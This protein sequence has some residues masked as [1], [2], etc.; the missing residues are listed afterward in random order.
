MKKPAANRERYAHSEMMKLR[1]E[2]RKIAAQEPR[3]WQADKPWQGFRKHAVTSGGVTIS[4]SGS[5]Q[6]DPDA[7][8]K[9]I[10]KE[11]IGIFIDLREEI[12]GFV[13]STRR[14]VSLALTNKDNRPSPGVKT[15]KLLKSEEAALAS[16]R[17]KGK[18]AFIGPVNAGSK[19]EKI[20]IIEAET[21]HEA[22]EAAGGKARYF[23]IP[24]TDEMP[25]KPAAVD[26]LAEVFKLALS[27]K[28]NIH[29]HCFAGHGRTTT[30]LVLLDI[31]AGMSAEEAM[32]VESAGGK[33]LKELHPGTLLNPI[34]MLGAAVR[35]GLLYRFQDYWRAGSSKRTGFKKYLKENP[36]DRH[37]LHTVVTRFTLSFAA[38]EKN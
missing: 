35:L 31:M 32:S 22:I 34:K 4:I 21:E 12:H 29:V 6:P 24:I 5:S 1:R 10:A 28:R 37:F 38:T 26:K 33:N 18:V 16:L 27:E 2:L 13:G 7:I 25:P 11:K 8:G 19:P 20:K 15:G 36:I 14:T 9:L 3:F 30:G 23:R 17:K